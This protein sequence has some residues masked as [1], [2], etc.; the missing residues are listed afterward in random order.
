MVQKIHDASS[1][2]VT[3]RGGIGPR[4][5][6][7]ISIVMAG[8]VLIASCMLLTSFPDAISLVG[9]KQCSVGAPESRQFLE[10]RTLGNARA[11]V[12]AEPRTAIGWV[13]VRQC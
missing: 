10:A 4:G 5:V 3:G 11:G 2:V 8:G 12:A 13:G 9:H 7:G 1:I 6:T